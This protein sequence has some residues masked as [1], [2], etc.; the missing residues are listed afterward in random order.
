MRPGNRQLAKLNLEIAIL[1]FM[2]KLHRRVKRQWYGNFVS[3][4]GAFEPRSGSCTINDFNNA[5]ELVN[6]YCEAFDG[7]LQYGGQQ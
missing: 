4:S 2:L 7:H 3:I 1:D 6:L 5:S